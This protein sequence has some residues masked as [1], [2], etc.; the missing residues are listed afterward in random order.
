[1]WVR[2]IVVVG[3]DFEKSAKKR[4][5]GIRRNRSIAGPACRVPCSTSSF[6]LPKRLM[7]R[8][9]LVLGSLDRGP[10]AEELFLRD[11]RTPSDPA[12]RLRK[13]SRRA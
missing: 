3:N 12:T 2:G 6:M 11:L 5:G 8:N 7:V 10:L 9:L 4:L 13:L 1:M